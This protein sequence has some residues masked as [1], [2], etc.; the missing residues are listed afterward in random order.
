MILRGKIRNHAQ[1]MCDESE[2]RKIQI[3]FFLFVWSPYV[4]ES[5]GR[6]GSVE[7]VGGPSGTHFWAKRVKDFQVDLHILE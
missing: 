5:P 7:V 1:G 3:F 4:L 6:S 2:S